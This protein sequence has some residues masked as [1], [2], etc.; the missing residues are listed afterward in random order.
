M[1]RPLPANLPAFLVE[2][3]RRTYAGLDDD[4]TVSTPLLPASKQLEYSAGNL[5]YRDIYFGMSFFVGQEVV[6]EDDQAIWSMSYAGGLRPG[7]S[8]RKTALAAY[9]FLRKALLAISEERPFRGPAHFEDADHG[10]LNATEG[11]IEDFHGAEQIT[12]RGQL[13]YRLRYCGGR[14]R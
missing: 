3:K 14:L 6:C 10:Y 7:I 9:A 5:R 12:L 4:A 1:E 11:S 13:I 8:D 2:A